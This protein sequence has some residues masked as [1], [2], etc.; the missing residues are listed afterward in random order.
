MLFTKKGLLLLVGSLLVDSN[1]N[2][3][4]NAQTICDDETLNGGEYPDGITVQPGSSCEI[5]NVDM[6]GKG[7]TC[8]GCMDLEVRNTFNIEKIDY[9]NPQQDSEL[10]IRGSVL[11]GPLKV[12]DGKNITV[13][14][15]DSCSSTEG[16]ASVLIEKL[17]QSSSVDISQSQFD[18]GCFV[19][20]YGQLKVV[21]NKFSTFTFASVIPFLFKNGILFQLTLLH[22]KGQRACEVK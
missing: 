3:M 19:N 10:Q 13:R 22:S 18:P 11:D 4:A 8:D 21:D 20:G 1:N 9:V 17:I 15:V 2:N 16:G 7:I 6:K 12:I 5:I 14:I